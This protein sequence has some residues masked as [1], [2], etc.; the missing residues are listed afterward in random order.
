MWPDEIVDERSKRTSHL[1]VLALRAEVKSGQIGI[2]FI[3]VF[4]VA[5][6]IFQ[7]GRSGAAVRSHRCIGGD[8][9]GIPTAAAS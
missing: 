1:I 7:T 2:D 8:D 5:R 6:S 3:G 4:M 9:R